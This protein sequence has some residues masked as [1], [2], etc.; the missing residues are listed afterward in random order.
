M[1]E[2]AVLLIP[3]LMADARVFSAQIA[4]LSRQHPIQI[5]NLGPGETV[6]DMARDVLA[7]APARFALAGQGLGGAVAMEILRRAPDR[8]ARLALINAYPLAETPQVAA[9]REPRLTLA[10]AGRLSEAIEAEF[11]AA[12]LC[13][14]PGRARIQAQIRDMALRLGTECYTRQSR[15]LM[16]RPDQQRTLRTAMV[17]TYVICGAHDTLVPMKRHEFMA[18]LMP[19]ALLRVIEGAGHR[20]QHRGTRCAERGAGR[21]AARALPAEETCEISGRSGLTAPTETGSYQTARIAARLAFGLS[22][23]AFA[24]MKSSTSGRIFLRQDLPAKMP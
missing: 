22:S 1:T 6:G 19:Y 24:S 7:A 16:R 10:R 2:E 17:Q 5:A 14:G 9:D 21:L 18:E 8:L 15:A 3:G 11:P 12:S 4:V 23:P 20:A 13:P